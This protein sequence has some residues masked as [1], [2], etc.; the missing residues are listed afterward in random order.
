MSLKLLCCV[1]LCLIASILANDKATAAGTEG[2]IFSESYIADGL[3]LELRGY[4]LMR[5]VIFVKGS[6]FVDALFSVWLGP[7]PI[8]KSLKKQLL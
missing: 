1:G 6:E 2:V 4:G 8:D 7:Y 5:Y 3:E